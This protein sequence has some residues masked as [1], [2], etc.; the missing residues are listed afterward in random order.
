[1]TSS[2]PNSPA[3]RD[4]G[5]PAETESRVLRGDQ[6]AATSAARLDGDLR[7]GKSRVALSDE[8][9]ELARKSATAQGYADGWAEGQRAAA[10]QLR[11]EAERSAAAA[12]ET[13]R[14]H[15]E[16]LG[17]ALAALSD[18]A[19]D[20]EGRMAE[21]MSAVAAELA[22]AAVDLAEAVL[23]RELALSEDPG[24]DALRRALAMAPANRPVVVRLN[25]SE[26]AAVQATLDSGAADFAI[27][28]EIRII[29]DPSVSAAGCVVECDATRVD[30]QLGP[31]L[32]RV[33]EVLAT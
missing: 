13:Q 23:G 29:P 19:G 14:L 1:M 21:P 7:G 30:A 15:A 31:A 6:A 22:G 5:A 12:A 17:R 11:A 27:G 32:A 20:L 24:V 10:A 16:A 28:R 25:P 33:W 8:A 4:R 18:A 2:W 9:L 3:R 26:S